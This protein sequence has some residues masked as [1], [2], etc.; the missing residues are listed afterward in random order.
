MD[1]RIK[2][3]LEGLSEDCSSMSKTLLEIGELD[4]DSDSQY[5]AL[6]GRFSRDY[7]KV[8][9]IISDTVKNMEFLNSAMNDLNRIS[10]NMNFLS[11]NAAIE[12]AEAKEKSGKGFEV[13]AQQIGVLSKD[14]S[15]VT[16]NFVSSGESMFES[17]K[18]VKRIVYEFQD[19]L[20]D[21]SSSLSHNDKLYSILNNKMNSLSSELK[22]ILESILF[23]EENLDNYKD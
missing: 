3:I 14:L 7:S 20:E 23:L 19:L 21:L 9:K 6:I 22:A 15:K 10:T 16:D 17:L 5:V 2:V 11:L 13:V 1:S 4:Y 18:M 8:L 12:S